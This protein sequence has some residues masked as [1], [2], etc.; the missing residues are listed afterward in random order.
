M[1]SKLLL[2]AYGIFLLSFT[3]CSNSVTESKESIQK[4]KLAKVQK[5]DSLINKSYSAQIEEQSRVKASFRAAGKIEQILV[6]EGQWVEAGT[7]LAT[8][9]QRDYLVQY[10]V[11]LAQYEQV[12]AEADRVKEMFEKK[13]VA[14]NDFDK[15]RAGLKM[16]SEQLNHAKH[17]LDD[18][19]LFASTSGYV[20]KINYKAGELINI[21]Y[22]LLTLLNVNS[23]IVKAQISIDDYLRLNYLQKAECNQSKL[24]SVKFPLQIFEYK[25]R[26]GLNQLYE[27]SFLLKTK[28][29][30]L[31]PGM[32]VEV[33][34][35]FE[36]KEQNVLFIPATSIIHENGQS[37]VWVFNESSG[38]VH[39]Q[40]VEINGMYN[41][42]SVGVTSGLNGDEKIVS[43]GVSH[44][45]ENQVV[46][47]MPEVKATNIGGEL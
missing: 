45:K 42:S 34:L 46:E 1:D 31:T 33:N 23:L 20:D 26:S 37:F 43:A 39:K 44:L 41:D 35:N 28:N 21:G 29:D 5:A 25:K 18:T 32:V 9:D 16:V 47:P 10:N 22:P 7:L 30:M 8:L 17:Q 24:G 36:N 4:V 15:A 12:K 6:S 19:K 13:S 3:N 2:I 27:V 38:S 40:A 14:A 11:A